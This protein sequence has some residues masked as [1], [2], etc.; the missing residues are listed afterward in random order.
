[1]SPNSRSHEILMYVM[2]Y[3]IIF[4]LSPRPP[5]GGGRGERPL[6][7][8]FPSDNV[9]LQPLTK[10]KVRVSPKGWRTVFDFPSDNVASATSHE[11]KSACQPQKAGARSSIFRVQ[12]YGEKSTP[13]IPKNYDFIQVREYVLTIAP[14]LLCTRGVHWAI[15]LLGLQPA[16]ATLI[17]YPFISNSNP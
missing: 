17:F 10:G 4:G 12:S 7:Q 3:H 1:M 16:F 13:A 14:Q 6:F 15:S 8:Y 9:A 11:G 5:Y 2:R